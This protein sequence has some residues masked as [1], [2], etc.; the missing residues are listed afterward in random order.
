MVK[1]EW[2]AMVELCLTNNEDNLKFLDPSLSTDDR[3]LLSL[4]TNTHDEE[5]CMI[6]LSA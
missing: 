5:F 6:Q 3:N 1:R 4:S 2:L